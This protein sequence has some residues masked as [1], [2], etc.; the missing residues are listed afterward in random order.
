MAEIRLEN[1]SKSFGS[2][3]IIEHLNLTIQDLSLIHI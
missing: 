1:V 3:K 2:A